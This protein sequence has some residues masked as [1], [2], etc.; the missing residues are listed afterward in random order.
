[1]VATGTLR[2]LDHDVVQ[3]AAPGFRNSSGAPQLP[4]VVD[5]CAQARVADKLLSAWKAPNVTNRRQNRH[6]RH[7]LDT[8][9]LDQQGHAGVRGCC[10][11]KGVF[12]LRHLGLG[13]REGR[14]IRL[15]ARVF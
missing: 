8:G 15:D 7:E 3:I 11:R 4:T 10:R 5:T 6:R 9:Q 13:K 14:Q 12:E 2:S 1:M